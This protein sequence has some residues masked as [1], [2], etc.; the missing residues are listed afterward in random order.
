LE[1]GDWRGEYEVPILVTREADYRN[2]MA[3]G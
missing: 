3:D 2:V 1:E